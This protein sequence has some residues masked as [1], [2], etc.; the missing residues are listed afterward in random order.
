MGEEEGGGEK[1][2]DPLRGG[3]RGGVREGGRG[4]R[5]GV[6]NGVLTPESWAGER[7]GGDPGEETQRREFRGPPS[8]RSGGP[9]AP[10]K[11]G[12]GKG[13]SGKQRGEGL[14]L[15]ACRGGEKQ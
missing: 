15:E 3:G 4:R 12:R 7:R 11:P 13:G 10:F 9:W 8:L 5:D 6:L 2:E 1:K 14:R